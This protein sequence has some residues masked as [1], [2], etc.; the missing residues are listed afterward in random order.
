[1]KRFLTSV[2]R[3]STGGGQPV[4]STRLFPYELKR[5]LIMW[6]KALSYD[7][8]NRICP[9]TGKEPRWQGANKPR[10]APTQ[11]VINSSEF[12]RIPDGQGDDELDFPQCD[13]C[14]VFRGN[15]H[16]DVA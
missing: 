12:D 8:R 14:G 6:S 9:G 4:G 2:L 5:S 15:L 7:V 1:V 10:I 11:F 16:L 3:L 13:D